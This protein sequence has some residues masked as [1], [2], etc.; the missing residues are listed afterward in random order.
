MKI[1]S[2]NNDRVVISNKIHSSIIFSTF[3][4]FHQT[5]ENSRGSC[6]YCDYAQSDLFICNSNFFGN[7]AVYLGGAV[8]INKCY[9]FTIKDSCFARNYAE[10]APDLYV[11]NYEKETTY[12]DIYGLALVGSK[13]KYHGLAIG[14]ELTS[15]AQYVNQSYFSCSNSD[16]GAWVFVY[17]YNP[18]NLKYIL[19]HENTH[20]YLFAH[21]R[22]GE[23]SIININNFCSVNDSIQYLFHFN[24][25]KVVN[26]TDSRFILE[27]SIKVGDIGN[28]K[29]N[30]CYSNIKFYD[31]ITTSEKIK[32]LNNIHNACLNEVQLCTNEISYLLKIISFSILSIYLFS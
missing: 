13:A 26:F 19:S 18:I 16:W 6:V 28:V 9:N 23:N 24:T 8:G 30:Y 3:I 15:S 12:F 32:A 17:V 21:D 20:S 14:S 25:G 29:F 5:D 1:D 27:K 7:S 22:L 2:L 11:Q 31:P 4:D 10:N